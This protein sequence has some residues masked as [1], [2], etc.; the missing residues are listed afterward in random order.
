MFGA[1]LA[2]GDRRLAEAVLT[3]RE[4]SD[5]NGF[6]NS[7][8][9]AHHRIYPG[10]GRGAPDAYAELI[11]SG[12]AEFEGGPAWKGDVDLRLFESPTE[13]LARLEVDEIIGGYYRQVG[14]QVGR[15][16][17]LARAADRGLA[18]PSE[19]RMS[20][21]EVEGVE[22]DTRHWINGERVASATTFTDVS[23]IDE[24]AAG[25]DR[26]RRRGRGGS[27]R[28]CRPRRVP[29]LG[30]AAGR[31]AVGDPAPAS[32]TAST[33]A[34]RTSPGWRPATTARCCARTVAA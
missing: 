28:R 27:R 30:R 14:R 34:P 2:A 7:H 19:Q 9:M 24:T 29:G 13:E 18:A 10:I 11:S 3:L 16:G 21:I 4:E 8:P 33:P 25:R 1:T 32:P 26:R 23:P 31:R 17:S 12:A 22:V 5:T 6:V 20:T 15:R